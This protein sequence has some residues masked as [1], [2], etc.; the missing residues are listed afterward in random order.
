LKSIQ[1]MKNVAKESGVDLIK[2]EGFIILNPIS[3]SRISYSVGLPGDK[4]ETE[5]EYKGLKKHIYTVLKKE[6]LF[7]NI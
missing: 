5:G 1:I 2:N 3:E 4:L 6:I 7:F